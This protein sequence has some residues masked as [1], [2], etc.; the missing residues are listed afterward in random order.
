[1]TAV[2][3]DL[4]LDVDEIRCR[5][6]IE[7]NEALELADALSF[8]IEVDEPAE[9]R[10]RIAAKYRESRARMRQLR[11]LLRVEEGNR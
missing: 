1:M 8:A 11:T 7:T 9:R 2:G 10:E 6:L 3:Y 4:E 5:L